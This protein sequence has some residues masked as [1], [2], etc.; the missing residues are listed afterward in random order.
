[1]TRLSW[2]QP[3]CDDCW[4][5]RN[6]GREAIRVRLDPPVVELCVFCVLPTTS[7]IYVRIDPA[8]AP[9]PTLTR[10]Q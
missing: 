3:C 2:T 10:E 8:T 5:D 6:P 9:Y 7:G 1:M 4:Q